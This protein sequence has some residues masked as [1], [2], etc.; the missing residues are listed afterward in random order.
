MKILKIRDVVA[1]ADVPVPTNEYFTTKAVKTHGVAHYI[2]TL[3]KI[4]QTLSA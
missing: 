4:N 1:H 3:G 2:F